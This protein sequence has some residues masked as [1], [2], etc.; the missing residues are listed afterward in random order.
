[1]FTLLESKRAKINEFLEYIEERLG[2][3]ETEKEELKQY[4]KWDK[5]K[6][7]VSLFLR[8]MDNVKKSN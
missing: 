6:R 8:V 2:T 5:D 7:L 4:Q 3:L 1:M